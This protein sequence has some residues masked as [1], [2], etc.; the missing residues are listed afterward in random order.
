LFALSDL[1]SIKDCE[2]YKA[3][4][5]HLECLVEEKHFFIVS[6]KDV[7]VAKPRC[8]KFAIILPKLFSF[9]D[10]D[11]HIEWLLSKEK[12]E[13]ALECAENQAKLVKDA[14]KHGA[15]TVAR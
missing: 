10:V 9:R 6:P 2:S 1:L 13:E 7:V 15:V 5:Y 14:A 8:I 3:K 11:D 12:F 4:D